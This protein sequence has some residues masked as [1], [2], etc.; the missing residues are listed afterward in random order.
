M[1]TAEIRERFLKFFEQNAHTIVESSGSITNTGSE[2]GPASNF[3]VRIS[4]GLDFFVYKGLK[5]GVG[6]MYERFGLTFHPPANVVP[7]KNATSAVDQYFGGLI[8]VG[9]VL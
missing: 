3:G 1:K 2:Y 5:I 9:Y 4:G 8:S 6:G 7:A